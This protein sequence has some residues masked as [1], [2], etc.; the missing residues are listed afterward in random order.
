MTD[1]HIAIIGH[2]HEC[3]ELHGEE[4][5]H[6]EHL[7]E[8]DEEADG[9]EVKLEDGQDLGDDDEAEQN[10]QQREEAGST[11]AHAESPQTNGD[12]EGGIPMARKKKRLRGRDSQCCY[13]W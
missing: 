7:E 1:G 8:V 12:Q 2:D 3:A 9:S 11:W 6:D 4:T 5:V 10:V 13:L